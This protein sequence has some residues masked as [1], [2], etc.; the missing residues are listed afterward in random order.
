VIDVPVHKIP[1][2]YRWGD[3]GKVFPTRAAAEAQGRAAYAN[4][5]AEKGDAFDA[6]FQ[7]A[8]GA[9]FPAP[10]N[11][12]WGPD[13]PTAESEDWRAQGDRFT[14]AAKTFPPCPACGGKIVELEGLLPSCESCHLPYFATLDSEDILDFAEKFVDAG[15]AIEPKRDDRM[16]MTAKS[17]R[18]ALAALDSPGLLRR[19]AKLN[20]RLEKADEGGE[21]R[22][23]AGLPILVDRPKG[24]VQTGTGRDGSQWSRTYLYD[25]GYIPNTQGGDGEGLDVY[26]GPNEDAEHAYWIA[27]RTFGGDDFD[28]W[29]VFLGFPSP[30]RAELAFRLHTPGELLG[31]TFSV[32]VAAMRTLLNLEPGA[33]AGASLIA[34][35]RKEGGGEGAGEGV[36]EVAEAISE[37]GEGVQAEHGHSG[38]GGKPG[39]HGGKPKGEKPK[40][41]HGGEG[42]GSK[43]SKPKGE[44]KPKAP[45]EHSGGGDGRARDEHGRFASKHARMIE[46]GTE[47]EMSKATGTGA[48]DLRKNV[49]K[50]LG[51]SFDDLRRMVEAAIDAAFPAPVTPGDYPCSTYVRDMFDAAA[52]FSR[53]GVL[54]QIGYSYGNGVVTL[55]GQP[56]EVVTTYAPVAGTPAADPNTVETNMAAATTKTQTRKDQEGSPGAAADEGGAGDGVG[57]DGADIVLL[58]LDRLQDLCD[59]IEAGGGVLTPELR[60]GVDGVCAL[61]E[62]VAPDGDEDDAGTEAD[63]GLAAGEGAPAPMEASAKAAK[64][65]TAKRFANANKFVR[66]L[67]KAIR[68]EKD[69]KDA[70]KR[71][72]I[73]AGVAKALQYGAE[74]FGS[75]NGFQSSSL[76]ENV[77]EFTDPSQYKWTEETVPSVPDPRG[78]YAEDPTYTPNANSS[79][80]YA[81]GE[82]GTPEVAEKLAK[83]RK[84]LATLTKSSTTATEPVEK[85]A[86]MHMAWGPAFLAT[87][88][89]SAFLHVESGALKDASGRSNLLQG[90]STGFRH[91]A[92]KDQHGK[93]NS[94]HIRKALN[95]IPMAGLE[96]AVK[97]ALIAQAQQLLKEAEE[98][99]A[100]AVAKADRGD[101]GWPDDMNAPAPKAPTFGRDNLL[102]KAKNRKPKAGT[103]AVAGK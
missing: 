85:N 79:A 30:A 83:L 103:A 18:R 20:A 3:H 73:K 91:W 32:P 42:G 49:A 60:S 23:F 77:P 57:G 25:Y 66:H 7:Q 51:V 76:G 94:F 92:I 101:H 8:W 88:P 59:S 11:E 54:Y 86:G 52:V 75:E 56:V 31:P 38:H 95:E 29:K 16:T 74:A 36:K 17:Y 90:P 21:E 46:P 68:K 102:E 14:L 40:G 41:G 48:R 34:S 55:T 4:G 37:L 58:A 43:E 87:L 100:S 39:A 28:E 35:M 96:T 26:L 27:Q 15:G 9:P 82:V 53:D 67:A 24:F 63:D 65:A 2:G 22:T 69:E 44:K 72:A 99:E 81:A 93:L 71:A 61:L 97:Q 98:E 45:K 13:T 5:F 33:E 1:G 6:P 64:A 78:Q 19:V 89:D 70:K 10:E 50:D 62:T 84:R 12:P 80:A 47:A